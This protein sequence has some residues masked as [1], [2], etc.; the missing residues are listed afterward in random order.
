MFLP[1]AQRPNDE[2]ILTVDVKLQITSHKFTPE[3]K[4]NTTQE[5]KKF[6]L[7]FKQQVGPGGATGK[8]ELVRERPPMGWMVGRMWG[9]F[10]REV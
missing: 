2:V 7:D 10:P 9:N 8:G 5:Y 1:P 3:L 4:D 6:T